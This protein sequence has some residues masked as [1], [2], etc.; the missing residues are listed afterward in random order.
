LVVDG[1]DDGED[2]GALVV[3]EL[4]EVGEAGVEDVLRG[5]QGPA[6][7]VGGDEVSRRSH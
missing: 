5:V 6:G 7:C 2:G 4:A 3:G 1:V